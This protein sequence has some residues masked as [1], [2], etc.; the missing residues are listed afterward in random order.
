MYPSHTIKSAAI[1]FGLFGILDFW[2]FTFLVYSM[3]SIARSI[4]NVSKRRVF[5]VGVGMTKFEKP[6]NKEWDYPDMGKIAAE[7]ALQDACVPYSAVE[8]VYELNITWEFNFI[9]I[10]FIPLIYF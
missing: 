1:V 3:A 9:F 10:L 6:G 7:R 2:V 8:Q 4:A 5:V